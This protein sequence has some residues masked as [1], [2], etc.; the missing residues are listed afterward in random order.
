MFRKKNMEIGM[1]YGEK[2]TGKDIIFVS[3][4]KGCSKIKQNNFCL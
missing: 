2:V 3:E 4:G 1:K